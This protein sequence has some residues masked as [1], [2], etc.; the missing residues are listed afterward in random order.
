MMPNSAG[1]PMQDRCSVP[2]NAAALVIDAVSHHYGSRCALKDVSLE[3]APGS[4]TALLGLNGA[5]K[6][7]L[8]SLVTRLFGVQR[9]HIHIF[10]HDIGREPGEALRRLGV[11]FQP[12]TLDLDLS[13]TQNLLYHA[14]L[15]GI[16][17]RE[18]RLRAA[19]LLAQIALSD[20][21]ESRVRDLSGGQMRR[22]EIARALLHRPQLLL[23]DE[24]T[25]GL[26]IRSRADMLGHL[27]ALV[28]EQGIGVLYATHLFDE[29]DEGDQI[30]VLHQGCVLAQG[31]LG[32]ILAQSGA[33]DLHAAFMRLTAEAVP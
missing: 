31:R 16:G 18:A 32:D 1:L 27:R 4:F 28:R 14:A 5:G 9:G 3:V 23:L 11:V 19:D 20:R 21:G 25:V 10:G 13:V 2:A 26:D 29:I 12:R 7:T 24:P 17:R 22:L 6:S 33:R 15:H 8:V 30:V